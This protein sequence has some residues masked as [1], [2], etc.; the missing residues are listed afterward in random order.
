MIY[1]YTEQQRLNNRS[2][3]TNIIHMK[4]KI[5]YVIRWIIFIIIVLNIIS[6]F[7]DPDRI[8]LSKD[9]VYDAERKDILDYNGNKYEIPP[10]VI[11]Y[12]KID[13]KILV[14]W[15]PHYP[16]LAIYD[17][18]DYGF[19][20][21]SIILYWVLD[22]DIEKQIGPMDSIEFVNYCKSKGINTTFRK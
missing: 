15:N 21:D 18:Y 6:L 17:K 2:L 13:N 3:H 5:W 1:I 10:Y 22:L 4:K 19:S 8:K 20:N 14:K 12:C 11:D 16:I 9:V 7:Y